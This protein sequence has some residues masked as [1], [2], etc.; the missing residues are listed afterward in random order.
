MMVQSRNTFYY[1][2]QSIENSSL[3]YKMII[4]NENEETYR[5]SLHGCCCVFCSTATVNSLLCTHSWDDRWKHVYQIVWSL[6]SSPPGPVLLFTVTLITIQLQP[7]GV[8]VLHL[9]MFVVH[10]WMC[11]WL[12]H[13]NKQHPLLD[14]HTHYITSSISVASI[15]TL[16][17]KCCLGSLTLSWS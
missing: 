12:H 13:K 5:N 14:K 16:F 9:D 7:T 8:Q 1:S 3:S 15:L 6:S 4:F 10:C 2:E 17:C 11:V